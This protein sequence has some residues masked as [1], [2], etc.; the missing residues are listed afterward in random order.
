MS[1]IVLTNTNIS[2]P[3]NWPGGDGTILATG[4]FGGGS[5]TPQISPDGVQW[6]DVQDS[7]GTTLSV[8]DQGGAISFSVAACKMM[9][10]YTGT[11]MA[12][13]AEVKTLSVVGPA[14]TTAT[15][16]VP[17]YVQP[18]IGDTITKI[19][20]SGSETTYTFIANGATPSGNQIALG[21]TLANTLT[22]IVAKIGS[23]T[24]SGTSIIFTADTTGTAGNAFCIQ[25]RKGIYAKANNVATG[26]RAA[27]TVNTAGILN[28]TFQYGDPFTGGSI[29]TVFPISLSVGDTLAQV[30]AKIVNV[31]GSDSRS[32]L[33]YNFTSTSS[34]VVVTRK[35]PFLSNDSSLLL[36]IAN[37][38]PSPGF[39][40]ST[41]TSTVSGV[42]TL[43]N[44]TAIIS[45]R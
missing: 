1:K 25:I 22:A 12:G 18:K 44:I 29:S 10:S 20:S 32:S 8:T 4:N 33:Y 36:S 31:L 3:F 23:S 34:T 16:T 37:G 17:F 19:T 21:T 15:A 9:L 14:V 30:I 11:S 39:N 45:E 6:I 38:S 26:G 2:T 28:V 35:S 40:G 41:A 7:S 5:I 13:T 42:P 27:G 43:P 24:V